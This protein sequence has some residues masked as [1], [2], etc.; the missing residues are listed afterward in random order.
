MPE[1]WCKAT[2]RRFPTTMTTDLND[3][4]TDGRS[5]T[6]SASAKPDCHAPV[7]PNRIDVQQKRSRTPLA[8]RLRIVLSALERQRKRL[9]PVRALVQQKPQ[10]CCKACIV[11]SVR[12]KLSSL[13]TLAVGPNQARRSGEHTGCASNHQWRA[14]GTGDERPRIRQNRASRRCA[15]YP[16][17]ARPTE[18]AEK[19]PSGRGDRYRRNPAAL[20]SHV[21]ALPFFG[22][23]HGERD[24]LPPSPDCA[25]SATEAVAFAGLRV[26][27]LTAPPFAGSSGSQSPNEL[28]SMT[29]RCHA[30]C[31]G[32]TLR[33][34]IGQ[35]LAWGWRGAVRP[36]LHGQRA[37][38]LCDRRRRQGQP[39]LPQGQACGATG[40][41]L[42]ALWAYH[43]SERVPGPDA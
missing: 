10:V 16:G 12:S 11:V 41:V 30:R 15:H 35:R 40:K 13:P 4:A 42:A 2:L 14:L 21:G 43:E 5:F 24:A 39:H 6:H 22:H 8:R 25:E 32:C 38:D 34:I 26:T 1:K 19:Q 28:E 27:G 23:E 9:Q 37:R 36:H 18:P 17:R 29:C 20:A 33:A 31:P 7:A 3:E